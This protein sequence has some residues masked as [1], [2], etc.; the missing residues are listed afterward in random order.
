MTS[1]TPWITPKMTNVQ[2]GPCQR[3]AKAIEIKV[4]TEAVR[5]VALPIDRISGVYKYVVIN[6]ESVMCQRC[7]NSI[8]EVARYGARKLIGILNP[9]SAPAPIAISE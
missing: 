6:C 1:A 2:E 9:N 3:P 4:A 8:I 7:Q 5:S